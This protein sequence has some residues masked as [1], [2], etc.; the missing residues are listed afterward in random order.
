VIVKLVVRNGEGFSGETNTR[1]RARS[2]KA[3]KSNRLS[4]ERAVHVF[5]FLADFAEHYPALI[6]GDQKMYRDLARA[7]MNALQDERMCAEMSM[8]KDIESVI[9]PMV[10]GQLHSERMQ[11]NNS[12]E[13]STK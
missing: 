10:R 12:D 3:A 5:A 4:H 8:D 6:E 7:A 2:T 11:K 1:H 13:N 9:A